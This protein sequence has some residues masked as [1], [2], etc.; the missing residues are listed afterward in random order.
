MESLRLSILHYNYNEF[1]EGDVEHFNKTTNMGINAE[2]MYEMI[3]KK[4]LY[5]NISI[6]D[7]KAY[8]F[9]SQRDLNKNQIK[10]AYL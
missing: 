1:E 6:N 10:N 7:L 9:P 2:D 8:I 3:K 5:T 4:Y